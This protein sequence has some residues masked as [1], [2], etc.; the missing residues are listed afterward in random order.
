VCVCSLRYLLAML[1]RPVL[2]CSFTV[3]CTLPYKRCDFLKTSYCTWNALF[4]FL[5]KF[6]W[7]ISHSK[8]NSARCDHNCISVGLLHVKY[9]LLL[10]DFNES[11]SPSMV[12][13]KILKCHI[14]WKFAQWEPSCSVRT[15]GRTWRFLIVAFRNFGKAPKNLNFSGP[16]KKRYI[17]HNIYVLL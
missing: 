4:D 12:F 9:R 6:L 14:P 2:L 3:F 7:N 11:W 5:Y 15:Y 17:A 13:R 1:M 10:S 8:N 16:T